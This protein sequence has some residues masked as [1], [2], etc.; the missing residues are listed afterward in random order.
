MKPPTG[1]KPQESRETEQ[2]TPAEKSQAWVSQQEPCACALDFSKVG[3]LGREDRQP[4]REKWV[5]HK[6][7]RRREKGNT[8]SGASAGPYSSS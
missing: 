3:L 5:Q 6:K 1:I 2:A 4:E 8:L 7:E